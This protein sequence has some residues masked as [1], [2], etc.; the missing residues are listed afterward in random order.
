MFNKGQPFVKEGEQCLSLLLITQIS[1]ILNKKL[2]SLFEPALL[3]GFIEHV[4][5][6]QDLVAVQLG[7]PVILE[8]CVLECHECIRSVRWESECLPYVEQ[9]QHALLVRLVPHLVLVAVIEQH[10]LAHFPPHYLVSNFHA[11]IALR[12][13]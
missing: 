13:N 3:L 5:D 2:H 12:D 11:A 10:G 7:V 4:L 9:E 8:W 1:E 6:R